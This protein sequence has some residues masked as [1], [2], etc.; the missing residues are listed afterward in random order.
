MSSKILMEKVQNNKDSP[1]EFA[2]LQ[3]RI[4]NPIYIFVFAML[5]SNYFQD[6]QK[7]RFE[8]DFTNNIY[9]NNCI[10]YKIF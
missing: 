10:I 6:G 7:T 5:P 4:I 2:V 1:E 8:M 9:F 3:N